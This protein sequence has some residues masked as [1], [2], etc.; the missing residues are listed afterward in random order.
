MTRRRAEC[1]CIIPARYA[2]SRLPGKPLCDIGGKPLIRHVWERARESRAFSRIIVATDDRRISEAVRGFGGEAVMT[3]PRL[4]SGTDRVAAVARRLRVPLVMNLQGDEP[5]F[6]PTALSSLVSAMRK[7][8]SCRMATP[9]RRADWAA[10]GAN[11]A[12]VKV[13]V[14]RDGRA[15]YFSRSAIPHDRSRGGRGELLHHL[16]VYVYRRAF[17]LEFAS[18]RPT[19]LEAT[20]KLEQLRALEHGIPIRVVRVKTPALSVDTPADLSR[21]RAWLGSHGRRRSGK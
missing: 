19:P 2:S 3:S 11:P 1:A 8:P 10:I 9:A 6:A 14:A 5:F 15:L 17:L 7:D 12:A 16:G 21:A 13:A 18:W 20:E 4:P